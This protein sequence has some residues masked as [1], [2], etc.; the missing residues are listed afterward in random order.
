MRRSLHPRKS[1][2]HNGNGKRMSKWKW[3]LYLEYFKLQLT[4]T[5]WYNISSRRYQLFFLYPVESPS[6]HNKPSFLS[7]VRITNKRYHRILLSLFLPSQCLLIL[8]LPLHR[9][10]FKPTGVKP[11]PSPVNDP[12]PTIITHYEVTHVQ[13][14]MCEDQR[15]RVSKL[16]M[17]DD[18]TGTG[19]S[20]TL[21][22]LSLKNAESS[23]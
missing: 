23:R 9:H 19:D 17:S 21:R 7:E 20:R 1:T 16:P 8:C 11:S 4:G 2:F 10:K 6:H 18:D 14:L 15:H 5:R 12:K 3:W 22:S 13:V